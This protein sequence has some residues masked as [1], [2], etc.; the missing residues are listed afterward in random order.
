[1]HH[2]PDQCRT[3]TCPEIPSAE[4]WLKNRWTAI[5]TTE[6]PVPQAW[7]N[8]AARARHNTLRDVPAGEQGHSAQNF[9]AAQIKKQPCENVALDTDEDEDEEG[10][11]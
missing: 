4:D 3:K 7:S 9:A 10:D 2:S 8:V 11:E 5:I 6:L 1:V